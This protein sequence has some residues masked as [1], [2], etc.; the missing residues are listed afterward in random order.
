MS[1]QISGIAGEHERRGERLRRALDERGSDEHEVAGQPV[2]EDAAGDHDDRLEQRSRCEH[3][4]ELCCSSPRQ[5]EHGEG[6]GDM[7][8]VVAER[9]HRR[10][11]EEEAEL[12]LLE[13]AETAAV[14][15]RHDRQPTQATRR[16]WGSRL[17]AHT[18]GIRS[19]AARLARPSAADPQSTAS[20]PKASAA[21]P[22]TTRPTGAQHERPERFVGAD[23]GP[24][25]RRDRAAGRP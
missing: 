6:Q 5:V 16:A 3:E 13:R 9:R 23:A 15:A 10:G 12:A 24:R 18:D 19:T 8:H 21:G 14:P 7:P 4:P 20:V 17:I 22:A 25:L 11:G 1:D 2:R